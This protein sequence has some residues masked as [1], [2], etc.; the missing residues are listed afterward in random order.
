[1]EKSNS[2]PSIEMPRGLQLSPSQEK[3]IQR[4]LDRVLVTCPA[5]FILL[6]EI[7]GQLISVHGEKGNTD[8]GA[9]GALVAGD[10]SA[11]QEMARITGQYQHAQLILREGSDTTTFIS[12]VGEKMVLYMR[13]NKE[14]PLGWA[15]LMILQACHALLE[16]ISAPAQD[17]EKLELDLSEE[18]LNT[19]IEDG[20]DSIWHD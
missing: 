4:I 8:P 13:I 10:L 19:L 12:E 16:V 17:V 15:R 9:L 20:L 3:L 7:S 6:A 14:E 5:Q 2:E 18:Q 11:S 1:M